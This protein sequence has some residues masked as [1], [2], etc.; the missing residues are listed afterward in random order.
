MED[1]VY[2]G[3]ERSVVL[4]DVATFELLRVKEDVP[5]EVAPP[6]LRSCTPRNVETH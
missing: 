2:I 1:P 3:G 6:L 5:M 4:I